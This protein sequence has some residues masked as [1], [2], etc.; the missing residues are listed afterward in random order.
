MLMSACNNGTVYGWSTNFE[1]Y[2]RDRAKKKYQ[3]ETSVG[4]FKV[5]LIMKA[6]K[7]NAVCY[8]EEYDLLCVA[9]SDNKITIKSTENMHGCKDYLTLVM[10]EE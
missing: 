6:V 5:E 9:S 2:S 8:D 7:I 3:E 10:G 4:G 1:I